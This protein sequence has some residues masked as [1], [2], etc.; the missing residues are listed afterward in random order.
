MQ[1]HWHL[2]QKNTFSFLWSFVFS[3]VQQKDR[4]KAQRPCQFND[5][6]CVCVGLRMPSIRKVTN[7]KIDYRVVVFYCIYTQRGCVE[8]SIS[9]S[10]FLLALWRYYRCWRSH[11]RRHQH[12]H[13]HQQPQQQRL[14][15][16]FDCKLST[17]WWF[18]IFRKISEQPSKRHIT[19]PK[20]AISC[21]ILNDLKIRYRFMFGSIVFCVG[22]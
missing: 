9:F 14:L 17:E 10:I 11:C 2:T 15:I 8:N 21:F 1:F 6:E 12:H 18:I 4:K 3:Y 7:R 13:H 19:M 20:S 5:C 16:Y 22:A